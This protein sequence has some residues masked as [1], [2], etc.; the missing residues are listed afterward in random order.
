M[1]WGIGGWLLIPFM[2]KAGMDEVT[3]MRAR[4]AAGLTTTFATRFT[5]RLTL[6]EAL[7]PAAIG[8]YG[9]PTTGKKFL[10]TPNP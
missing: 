5:D 1:A 4:V 7:D 8:S 6:A 3:R 10:I 9:R 2:M